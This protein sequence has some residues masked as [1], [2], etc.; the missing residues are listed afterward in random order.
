MCRASNRVRV[1]RWRSS[2]SWWSRSGMRTAVVV[3]DLGLVV[4]EQG[5]PAV[6][7][8]AVQAELEDL[9][10][11]AA[12]DDDGLPDVPQAAVVRV[13]GLGEL[14]QVGLVRKRPGDIVGE[15]AAGRDCPAADRHGG[16]EGAVQA[17][18]LGS[19]VSSAPRRSRRAQ[20][21]TRWR[22]LAVTFDG[23][24]W[25]PLAA[26]RGGRAVHVALVGDEAVHVL[27]GRRA[28][29]GRRPGPGVP[30]TRSVRHRRGAA[31]KVPPLRGQVGERRIAQVV[32]QQ[33]A[34]PLLG[35]AGQVD[36]AGA[37][38]ERPPKCSVSM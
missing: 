30:G 17:D 5:Q 37:A 32:P 26:R 15:A 33:V 2:R 34:Q 18:A 7:A 31:S 6:A 9:A 19:P 14:L 27:A 24:P 21:K 23:L 3:A 20:L 22:E 16:D 4:P 10:A 36:V 28:G 1:L 12:G 35:D 13:V 29:R 25:T 38:G 11:A 8:D